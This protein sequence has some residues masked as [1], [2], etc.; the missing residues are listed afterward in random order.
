MVYPSMVWDRAS[1]M[2][3]RGADRVGKEK[4]ARGQAAPIAA[5]SPGDGPQYG[6]LVTN[7]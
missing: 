4:I 7:Q 1:E 5:H 2:T 6:P 3:G